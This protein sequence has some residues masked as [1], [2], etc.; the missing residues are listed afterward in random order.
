MHP[1]AGGATALTAV[2]GSRAVH[3]LGFGYVLVPVLLNAATMV[4]L[5]VAINAAFP[6]RRYPSIANREFPSSDS[7]NEPIGPSHAE[8][9][10]ALRSLD[11]FV[12]ITEEDLVRLVHLLERRSRPAIGA[13]TGT[14]RPSQDGST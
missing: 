4:G 11:S 10:A 8:V 2:L 3:D 9:V 5:A 14:S 13:Q 6:W 7:N 1:P 12:D